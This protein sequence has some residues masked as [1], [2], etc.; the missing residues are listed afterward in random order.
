[1]EAENVILCDLSIRGNNLSKATEA[2]TILQ[3]F[4]WNLQRENVTQSVI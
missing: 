3:D 1:M 4:K 2:H